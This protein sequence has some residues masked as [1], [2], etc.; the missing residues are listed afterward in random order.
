MYFFICSFSDGHWRSH[1]HSGKP[2][3]RENLQRERRSPRLKGKVHLVFHHAVCVFCHSGQIQV[4]L[5]YKLRK[6]YPKMK[7]NRSAWMRSVD[8][9]HVWINKYISVT[10][11]IRD[12][13]LISVF[14]QQSLWHVQFVC[15][16]QK[17][18]AVFQC[19][20]RCP[21][22]SV[23]E[24]ALDSF[25]SEHTFLESLLKCEL[26]LRVGEPGT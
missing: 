14:S 7:Q 8:L 24:I 25:D 3:D 20:C 6:R 26:W 12:F 1:C 18:S 15:C 16:N 2:G 11:V 19:C 17:H 23:S 9:W 22:I 21:R 10:S 5:S 13:S 4:W